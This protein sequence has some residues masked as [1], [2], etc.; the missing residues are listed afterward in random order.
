MASIHPDSV[1]CLT[2]V[3]ALTRNFPRLS[4]VQSTTT[5]SLHLP[6][7]STNLDIR[8]CKTLQTLNTRPHSILIPCSTIT[9]NDLAEKKTIQSQKISLL[10]CLWQQAP[11]NKMFIGSMIIC[12]PDFNLD[13]H[14]QISILMNFATFPS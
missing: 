12:L 2:T 4:Y 7:F 8:E 5:T 6:Y 9:S 13:K 10:M 11:R 1:S 14:Y 3:Q